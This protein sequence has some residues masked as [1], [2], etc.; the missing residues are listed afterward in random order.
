[1]LNRRTL[2]A[3]GSLGLAGLLSGCGAGR[4]GLRAGMPTVPFELLLRQMKYDVGTYLWRHQGDKEAV[5]RPGPNATADERKEFEEFIAAGQYRA[6]RD[7]EACVGQ[8]SLSLVK[9]KLTVTATVKQKDSANAGLEVPLNLVTISPSGS[10]SA[11][12]DQ[13]LTTT[14]EIFPTVLEEF[15]YIDAEPQARPEFA[16][17]PVTDTLEALRAAMQRTAD[18]KPCF[19]FGVEQDQKSNSVKFGF[20]VTRSGT[21]GGKLKI[22]F[23]SLGAESSETQTVANTIEVFFV[24]KGEFG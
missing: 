5:N 19:H 21:A 2:M 20:T 6:A 23:F 17:H 22:L 15:E 12:D 13:S 8:V 10:I 24:S 3:S 9:V 16:G 7:G 14:V 11:E 1:M 4:N 18:T